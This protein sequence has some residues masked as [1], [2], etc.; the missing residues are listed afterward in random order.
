MNIVL[1]TVAMNASSHFGTLHGWIQSQSVCVCVGGGGGRGSRPPPP[2]WNCQIISF[3]HVE[4]FRQ[5]PSG[6]S[7]PP[8]KIFWIRACS[9]ICVRYSMITK[10]FYVTDM[11]FCTLPFPSPPTPISFIRYFRF[12]CEPLHEKTNKCGSDTGLYN[13][14][15]LPPLSLRSLLLLRSLLQLRSLQL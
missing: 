4:I 15:Q 13:K 12:L 10:I 11:T 8:E 1:N 5:T 14:A 9:G 3:C 7:N 2:P 6:N